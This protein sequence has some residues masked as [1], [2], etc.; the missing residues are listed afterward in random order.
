[1]NLP[2]ILITERILCQSIYSVTT[3]NCCFRETHFG[4]VFLFAFQCGILGYRCID[5]YTFGKRIEKFKTRQTHISINVTLLQDFWNK[6]NQPLIRQLA[7]TICGCS[8][9][10]AMHAPTC[11]ICYT[12]HGYMYYVYSQIMTQTS[13]KKYMRAV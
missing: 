2:M 1:M 9:C 4:S 7:S 3:L 12:C 10:M 11:N 6:Y 8:Y 5:Y 13:P